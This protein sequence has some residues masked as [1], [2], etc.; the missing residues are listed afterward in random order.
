M[1]RTTE[2][3]CISARSI[4][5]CVL[6]LMTSAAF[7]QQDGLTGA[8][9]DPET[10]LPRSLDINP[11]ISALR[12]QTVPVFK[13][14]DPHRSLYYVQPFLL[15]DWD[16][17]N[18]QFDQLCIHRRE[19]EEKTINVAVQFWM[20]EVN[21]EIAAALSRYSESRVGPEQIFSYPYSILTITSGARF[22]DDAIETRVLERYPGNLFELLRGNVTIANTTSFLPMRHVPVKGT[23]GELRAIAE[24]ADIQGF[25]Y[26]RART[27]Q[28]NSVHVALSSFAYHDSLRRL[29]RDE[30]ARGDYFVRNV[31][32]TGSVGW[33][34]GNLFGGGA[35]ES[36]SRVVRQDSRARAVSG[37]LLQEAVSRFAASAQFRVVVEDPDGPWTQPDAL[38]NEVLAFVK[39]RASKIT[40]RIV[41]RGADD[42]NFEHE[43][44][45]RPAD[46]AGIKEM[47]AAKQ[48]TELGL[49]SAEA[50]SAGASEEVEG[51][52]VT[53]SLERNRAVS[54]KDENDVTWVMDGGRWLP[55]SMDLYVLSIDELEEEIRLD[56][57]RLLVSDAGVQR[58][59]LKEIAYEHPVPGERV[60]V[61]LSDVWNK[62]LREDTYQVGLT[63]DQTLVISNAELNL[64]GK[65]LRVRAYDVVFLGNAN[66][67]AFADGAR[68]PAGSNGRPG[69]VGE[70]NGVVG[71]VGGTGKTGG[72][73]ENGKKGRTP[74]NIYFDVLGDISGE[75]SLTI[76]ADG[77]QGGGGGRGGQG[78]P[79]GAGGHGLDG[80]PGNVF[81]FEPPCMRQPQNG[82]AG[83]RGGNGGLGGVGG[84]GGSG[85]YVSLTENLRPYVKISNKGGVG[86]PGGVGG[87]PGAGGSGGEKGSR[88]GA[89]LAIRHDGPAGATGD[90]GTKGNEGPRGHAGTVD[91]V[92]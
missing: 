42:W 56:F 39:D 85:G 1:N 17:Y 63:R 62:S 61:L 52:T 58:H 70:P 68:A 21:A 25:I 76:R 40:V 78:G 59:Q 77:E 69:G 51:R 53:G 16:S 2:T 57:E 12:G 55:T 54:H 19:G 67:R 9:T 65:G 8:A 71:M 20:P 72:A 74:K 81:L 31:G 36:D 14:L 33:N 22:P 47:I 84:G 90:A 13:D 6:A 46:S 4:A 60:R 18:R 49:T 7:A 73:G 32:R 50:G 27:I 28:R 79:G 37:N 48:Q 15:V 44:L 75:G 3:R 66:I 34:L 92:P 5:L 43:F 87:S 80:A 30:H 64:E 26:T 10:R 82:S 88:Y 35:R 24:Y 38:V 23:C 45:K 11:E 29:V 86:G 83:G 91:Y 89:C 41:K